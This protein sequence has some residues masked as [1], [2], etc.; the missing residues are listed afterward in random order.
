MYLALEVLADTSAVCVKAD[1][2]NSVVGV[3]R[4][5]YKRVCWRKRGAY[6]KAGVRENDHLEVAMAMAITRSYH[7]KL[8]GRLWLV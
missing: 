3:H 7:F 8:S 5:K 6:P 4:N 1:N 2:H